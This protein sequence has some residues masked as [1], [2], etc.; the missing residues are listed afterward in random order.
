[1]PLKTES[2]TEADPL[3][4][5]IEIGKKVAKV[6]TEDL[7]AYIVAKLEEIDRLRRS[8]LP[9]LDGFRFYL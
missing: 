3:A 2:D 8:N 1:M 4:P 7:D 5:E 9:G 6:T